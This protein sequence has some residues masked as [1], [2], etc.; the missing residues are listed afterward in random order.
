MKTVSNNVKIKALKHLEKIAVRTKLMQL[1]LLFMMLLVEFVMMFF[2]KQ[3]LIDDTITKKILIGCFFMITLYSIYN[4][5]VLSRKTISKI[6]ITDKGVVS[7]KSIGFFSTTKVFNQK[8]LVVKKVISSN[9][10]QPNLGKI[11]NT[12]EDVVFYFYPKLFKKEE[13][14]NSNSSFLQELGKI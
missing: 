1:V 2:V 11:Y 13:L 9:E 14:L 8:N 12:K 5:I 6:E 10:K 4:L 7:I 3:G